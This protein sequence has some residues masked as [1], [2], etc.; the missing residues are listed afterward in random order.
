MAVTGPVG[1]VPSLMRTATLASAVP[2]SVGVV[3]LVRDPPVG[4]V[5]SGT[6]G[7]MVSITTTPVPAALT[8]PA[9]S[10]ATTLTVCEPSPSGRAGEKFSVVPATVLVESRLPSIDTATDSPASPRVM[11]DCGVASVVSAATE[12]NGVAGAVVS[13]VQ[14]AVALAASALAAKRSAMP[15]PDAVRVST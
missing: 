10:V 7:A 12:T 2:A 6:A 3:S 13:H 15:L 4:A 14:A 5:I 1:V 8:L 11:L 9:A